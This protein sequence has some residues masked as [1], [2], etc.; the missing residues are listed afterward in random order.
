MEINGINF[1]QINKVDKFSCFSPFLIML[2]EE[3]NN[4]L[5]YSINGSP[6]IEIVSLIDLTI[7]KVWNTDKES[8]ILDKVTVELYK[9][10]ELI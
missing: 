10:N 9:G 2:P 7:K 5:S 1:S 6:K 4:E 8:K 3:I